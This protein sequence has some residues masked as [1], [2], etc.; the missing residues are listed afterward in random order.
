MAKIIKKNSPLVLVTDLFVKL[1]NLFDD[2]YF[3][4]SSEHLYVCDKSGSEKIFGDA[5]C[6]LTPAYVEA[7]KAFF[8]EI[9]S[10]FS[11]NIDATKNWLKSQTEL[12]P[13]EEVKTEAKKYFINDEKSIND[14]KDYASGVEKSFFPT[15]KELKWL[16]LGDDEIVVREVVVEK[17]F[18]QIQLNRLSGDNEIHNVTITPYMLPMITDKNIKNCFIACP[19][20]GADETVLDILIYTDFVPFRLMMTYIAVTLEW[21]EEFNIFETG[22]NF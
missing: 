2:C 17:N 9:P 21:D 8:D 15:D 16:C 22:Q 3:L 4:C 12:I 19:D 7:V 18:T 5:L 1:G 6:D 10:C 20:Y 11:S 14:V 13:T